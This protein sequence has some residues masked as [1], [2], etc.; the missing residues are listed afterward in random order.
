MSV[1]VL[2]EVEPTYRAYKIY[3]TADAAFQNGDA[4]TSLV[5]AAPAILSLEGMTAGTMFDVQVKLM[6]SA[7]NWQSYQV[8]DG[9]T[10][11]S[12]VEFN[13]VAYNFV[14]VLRTSGAG[15]CKAFAQDGPFN[16][17]K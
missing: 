10:L 6:V 1:Q 2:N 5:A 9:A 3:D 17:R 15:A 8:V 7:S 11:N 12:L 13:L 4:N 16:H 14:R